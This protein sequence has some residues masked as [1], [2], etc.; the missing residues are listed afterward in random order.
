MSAEKK[1]PNPYGKL[2]GPEHKAKVK[3][4]E[5]SLSH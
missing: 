3:E 4:V 5:G 2:G 1:V